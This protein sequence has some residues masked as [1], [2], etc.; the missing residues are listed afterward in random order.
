MGGL[1]DNV[2][3]FGIEGEITSNGAGGVGR[4]RKLLRRVSVRGAL[5]NGSSSTSFGGGLRFCS[6][7]RFAAEG[8]FGGAKMSNASSA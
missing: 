4:E 6:E 1:T 2:K 5:A 3:R 8:N 7:N